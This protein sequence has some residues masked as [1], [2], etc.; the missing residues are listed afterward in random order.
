V[1]ITHPHLIPEDAAPEPR[2]WTPAEFIRLDE[3]GYFE[4]DSH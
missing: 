4:E 2:R 3:D 1:A